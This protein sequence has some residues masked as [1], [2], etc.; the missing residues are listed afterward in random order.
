MARLSALWFAFYS[1][2]KA[3]W[4]RAIFVKPL[5]G[6]FMTVIVSFSCF[7]ASLSLEVFTFWW[8]FA[9]F[10]VLGGWLIALPMALYAVDQKVFFPEDK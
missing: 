5:M 2:E 10:I 7:N 3:F 1:I 8:W 9:L 4:H 6:I